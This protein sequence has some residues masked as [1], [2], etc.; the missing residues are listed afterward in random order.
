MEPAAPAPRFQAQFLDGWSLAE[1]PV[2]VEV[3]DD[4][5][6]RILTPGERVLGTWTA[7]GL[8]SDAM[9]E[10]GVLHVTHASV[11]QDTLVVRDPEL[12]RRVLAM[13]EQV[14]SLPGGAKRK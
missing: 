12:E 3:L 5:A 8:S 10:G 1:Q 13:C 11:P 6:L 4:V 14:S 2:W 9:Q 7:A